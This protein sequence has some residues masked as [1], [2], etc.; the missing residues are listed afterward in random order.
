MGCMVGHNDRGGKLKYER[1][2]RTADLRDGSVKM[3]PM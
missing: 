1:K 2:I 3:C